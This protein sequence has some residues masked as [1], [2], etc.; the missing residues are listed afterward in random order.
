MPGASERIQRS[1]LD[2]APALEEDG[3]RTTATLLLEATSLVPP[4]TIPAHH[5]VLHA[6]AQLVNEQDG[7]V[8]HRLP[9]LD[10]GAE[11]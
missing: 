9:Q 6:V 3:V 7:K 4:R 10:P 1:C 5:Q 11:A 2:R 8:V